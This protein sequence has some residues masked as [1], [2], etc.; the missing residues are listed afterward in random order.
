MQIAERTDQIH[1]TET[2]E[3]HHLDVGG[4]FE[5]RPTGDGAVHFDCFPTWRSA[6]IP[7]VK[8]ARSGK[9]RERVAHAARQKSKP[10]LRRHVLW[11]VKASI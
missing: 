11:I 4:S 10:S 8:G 1:K 9:L 7:P 3:F 6:L 2:P 5:F